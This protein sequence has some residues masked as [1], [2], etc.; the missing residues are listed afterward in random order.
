MQ[1]KMIAAMDKNRVIGKDNS[2]PWHIPSD[3]KRFKDLTSGNT[4]LMGRKTYESIGRPLPDRD[5]IVLSRQ[6]NLEISGVTVVNDIYDAISK[7]NKD[8]DLFIIGG[9]EIY[10]KFI[11][12]VDILYLTIV[13]SEFDGDSYFPIIPDDLVEIDRQRCDDIVSYD[14]VIYRKAYWR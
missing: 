6:E 12:L 1:I 5:N 7:S 14:F 10:A 13:N 4:V 11:Y 9:S 3:L 8:K 2:L